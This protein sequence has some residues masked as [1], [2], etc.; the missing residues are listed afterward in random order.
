M[1]TAPRI[2][3]VQHSTRKGT[4]Y[5]LVVCEV[6][7]CTFVDGPAEFMRADKIRTDHQTAHA[8]H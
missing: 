2:K 6:E 4:A 7:D 5:Y 1:S 3:V 8:A